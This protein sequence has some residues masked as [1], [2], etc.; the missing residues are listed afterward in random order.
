[1]WCT[2]P[3]TAIAKDTSFKNVSSDVKGHQ[4][5]RKVVLGEH[6]RSSLQRPPHRSGQS[7]Q[8]SDRCGRE[9][10][11]QAVRERHHFPVAALSLVTLAT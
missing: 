10:V 6:Q 1:M 8:Q 2:A 3:I 7:H 5:P 11:D 4:H 9:L